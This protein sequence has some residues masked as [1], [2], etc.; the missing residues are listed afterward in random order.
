MNDFIIYKD[1]CGGNKVYCEVLNNYPSDVYNAEK[2]LIDNGY[3]ITYAGTYNNN[4][5]IIGFKKQVD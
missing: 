1:E 2:W 4:Y 3:I 5:L